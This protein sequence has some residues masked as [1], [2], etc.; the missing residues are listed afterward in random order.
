M[1]VTPRIWLELVN[2][3]LVRLPDVPFAPVVWFVPE[4]LM[5]PFAVVILNVL[6][7]KKVAVRRITIPVDKNSK[8]IIV[9]NCTFKV[10]YKC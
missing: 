9:H 3:L 6:V 4:D 8:F 5:Q 10:E 1:K 2:A 7:S